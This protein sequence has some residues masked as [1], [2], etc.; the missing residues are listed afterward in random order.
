MPTKCRFKRYSYTIPRQDTERMNKQFRGILDSDMSAALA[1]QL[2]Q[3]ATR[4][5]SVDYIGNVK[6]FS[7]SFPDYCLSKLDMD[8]LRIL[9]C[10]FVCT[11]VDER[12]YRVIKP[13]DPT[14][15]YRCFR[16]W[17]SCR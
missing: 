3:D 7:F 16:K 1:K 5:Q 13:K 2:F 12:T 15:F 14:E 8:W 10:A 9:H 4:E 6:S 17:D 11:K